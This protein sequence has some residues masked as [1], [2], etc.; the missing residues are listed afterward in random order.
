MAA[1]APFAAPIAAGIGAA[2]SKSQGR[3]NRSAMR[4]AQ[5]ATQVDID[6]KYKLTL[7]QRK[8]LIKLK[9]DENN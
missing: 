1:A 8:S 6:N 4:E 7:E 9:K 2:S 3:K 5:E